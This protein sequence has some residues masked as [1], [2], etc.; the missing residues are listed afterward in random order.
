MEKRLRICPPSPSSSDK[1]ELPFHITVESKRKAVDVLSWG[2]APIILDQNDHLIPHGFQV[3]TY[4][5]GKWYVATTRVCYLSGARHPHAEYQF[6]LLDTPQVC[7]E[8]NW[9][10]SGALQSM[11]DRLGT[12]VKCVRGT[13]GA[14]Q[15]GITYPNVQRAIR[16]VFPSQ[17]L[18]QVARQQTSPPRGAKKDSLPRPVLSPPAL[19]PIAVEESKE[20]DRVVD[21]DNDDDDDSNNNDVEDMDDVSLDRLERFTRQRSEDNFTM[22]LLSVGE[23]EN[24]A[25]SSDHEDSEEDLD[26]WQDLDTPYFYNDGDSAGWPATLQ[27]AGDLQPKPPQLFSCPL[28]PEDC[29]VESCF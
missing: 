21:D 6:A 10:S 3:K 27:D 17:V 8:W 13:N 9:T 22:Q 15:I 5:K 28:L 24:N 26:L 19:V 20:I 4:Y 23:N 1:L 14:L 7:G 2:Q 29:P 25:T 18:A 16:E 11:L 12:R